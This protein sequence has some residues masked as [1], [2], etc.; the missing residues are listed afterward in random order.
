MN[1]QINHTGI[2]TAAAS[3]L[4]PCTVPFLQNPETPWCLCTV[5]APGASRDVLLLDIALDNYFRLCVERMD[6][7]SLQGDD[8]LE[9][10]SLVL[11]NACIASE[12]QELGQV[13]SLQA[14]PCVCSGRTGQHMQ[15]SMGANR[16]AESCTCRCPWVLQIV[17]KSWAAKERGMWVALT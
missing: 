6:K 2:C 13:T 9:L 4:I 8:L 16:E 10:V 17:C 11:R 3:L 7:S 1:A 5:Q 14:S 15:V 12:N